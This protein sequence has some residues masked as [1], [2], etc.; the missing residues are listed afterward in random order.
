MKIKLFEIRTKTTETEDLH[1]HVKTIEIDRGFAL[2]NA[3][4]V[5]ALILLALLYL[6]AFGC[7]RE[8]EAPICEHNEKRCSLKRWDSIEECAGG[9]WYNYTYP[10]GNLVCVEGVEV[11]SVCSVPCVEGE[12]VVK[13]WQT[14]ECLP[15]EHCGGVPYYQITKGV[16]K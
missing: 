9:H 16:V 14:W 15:G 1:N 4:V 6:S 10:G 2:K 11:V 3:G 12:K 7:D 8:E 13:L 5:L